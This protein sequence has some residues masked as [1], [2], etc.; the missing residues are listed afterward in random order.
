ML[1]N[2]Y[3]EDHVKRALEEDIGFGDIT[4]E[5]LA[6]DD[7]MLSGAL[8][9]RSDGVLCGCEVFK[10]VFR[11]L[12]PEVKLKFYFKDGDEIKKAIKLRIFQDLQSTCLWAK[13]LRLIMLRE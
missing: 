5:N 3:I 10:T 7:D 13:G 11:I 8:N 1:S 9:T 4:T 6:E 2:F 12:S